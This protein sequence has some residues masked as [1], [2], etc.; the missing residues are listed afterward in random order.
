MLRFQEAVYVLYA[1]QK[2]TQKT[3]KHDIALGRQRYEEAQRSRRS[4]QAKAKNPGHA[5]Q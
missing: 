4:R 5:R 3:T 1:F 2:K